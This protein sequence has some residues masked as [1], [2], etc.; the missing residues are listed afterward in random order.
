MEEREKNPAEQLER[1]KHRHRELGIPSTQRRRTIISYVVRIT[2]ATL[3]AI[4]GYGL[5]RYF[6]R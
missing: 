1:M 3:V 4:G 5:L 6:W 2:L